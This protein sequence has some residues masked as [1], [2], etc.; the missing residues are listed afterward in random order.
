MPQNS[1]KKSSICETLGETKFPMKLGLNLLE[2]NFKYAIKSHQS[3][4]NKFMQNLDVFLHVLKL[5]QHE[6]ETRIQ[7]KLRTYLNS[8]RLLSS[9]NLIPNPIN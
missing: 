3:D 6:N 1:T 9:S 8:K 5:F 2:L 4:L 7:R